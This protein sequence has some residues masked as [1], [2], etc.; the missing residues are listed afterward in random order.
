MGVFRDNNH[1]LQMLKMDLG[2]YSI[3]IPI[4][5]EDFYKFVI[6]DQTL[7]EFSI[8][9]PFRRKIVMDIEANAVGDKEDP[10]MLDGDSTPVNNLLRIPDVNGMELQ[11]I[12]GVSRVDPYNMLSNLSMSSSFET[13]E[14]FEDLAQA[15]EL[16]N[17][18]SAMIPP[19]TFEYIEPDKIRLYNNHVYNSKILVEVLYQHHP[20]L[21]TIT[22]TS[23]ASFYKLALVNA[24]VF[25]YN[26]LKH[27]TSMETAYG[28]I[29]LK[30]DDWSNAEGD[31][32]ELL[33]GWDDTYH[34]DQ[35]PFFWI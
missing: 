20:E 29:D 35:N 25:L 14:S 21:F 1:L 11:P 9:C 30:I 27:Y 17:L 32:K 19:K 13:L 22:Q 33:D 2:I 12:I 4:K 10:Q 3:P 6:V 5:E 28:H 31:K 15:Q 18:S 26:N 16:A 23:R 24:K 34:L 7:P 8:Y